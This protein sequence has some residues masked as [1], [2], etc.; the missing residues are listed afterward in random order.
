MKLPWLGHPCQTSIT[1][2][3]AS[4][5]SSAVITPTVLACRQHQTS[6]QEVMNC[7]RDTYVSRN[8]TGRAT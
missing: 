7:P 3:H 5:R 6:H 2:L 4:R 1:M 8:G